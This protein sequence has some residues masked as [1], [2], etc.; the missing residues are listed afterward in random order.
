[1]TLREKFLEYW[2][3]VNAMG[4]A[5]AAPE[6][7]QLPWACPLLTLLG[8]GLPVECWWVEALLWGLYLWLMA[9]LVSAVYRAYCPV[10]TTSVWL[11]GRLHALR[12][13][14]A[15]RLLSFLRAATRSVWGQLALFSGKKG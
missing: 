8:S 7:Q 5:T 6:R 14:L 1:M 12:A 3:L 4:E 9:L 15:K 13:L 2:R 11:L 10:G